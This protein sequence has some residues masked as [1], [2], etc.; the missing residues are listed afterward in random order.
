MNPIPVE[1]MIAEFLKAELHSSR[2][3]AGSLKALQM[4]GFDETLIEQPDWNNP[5]QNQ[6]RAKVLGLCRG[7]PNENLFTNFPSDVKWFKDNVTLDELK[8]SYRLKS[9]QQMNTEERSLHATA[10]KVMVN[11]LVKN[12]NNDLIQQIRKKIQDGNT[13]PPIILVAQTRFGKKVVLEGHSRSIA[14]CTFQNT[15]LTVPVII[16]ISDHMDEWP[17]F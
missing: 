12:V 17:Y 11:K 3:R 6:K 1:Q 9:S 2:F 14:Y 4:C 8:K 10:D 16:G 13:L 5:E 15:E 7:W